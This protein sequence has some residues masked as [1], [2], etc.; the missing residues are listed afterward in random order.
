MAQ[1]LGADAAATLAYAGW[2]GGG[3]DLLSIDPKSNKHDHV[4]ELDW[5][6]AYAA[7]TNPQK[8]LAGFAEETNPEAHAYILTRTTAREGIL[9]RTDITLA[10]LALYAYW[11]SRDPMLRRFHAKG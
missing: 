3:I 10:P 6:D 2:K 9:G 11:L 4:Y 8:N 1:W 5:D 7:A